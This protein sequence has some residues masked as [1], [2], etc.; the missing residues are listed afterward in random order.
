[1]KSKHVANSNRSALPQ[2]A[3]WTLPRRS[4]L[5]RAL[6]TG[7]LAWAGMGVL[8]P[9]WAQSNPRLLVLGDS[10]SA[11]YGIP[12][13]SGWVAQ[14]GVQLQA[15]AS[16]PW[17]LIN[18]SMS[19]ETTAGGHAR[20]PSLLAKHRPQW[21]I[22]ELGGNDALRGL[23]LA[24]TRLKLGEMIKA[25]TEAGARVLLIGIQ[26]PP[27]YGP[28]YNQGLQQIYTQLAAQNKGTLLLPFFL[29]GVA[30][31]PDARRYFLDDGIH[32]NQAAQPIL[33]RN[34]WQI[35][36]KALPKKKS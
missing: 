16:G 3:E 15:H 2:P 27:N 4:F 30:D 23:P 35:L 12:R 6:W 14:L 8:T 28:D 32:P 1:M 21:V 10:L 7:G 22:L 34:V 20:L 31:G 11:E 24:Q 36:S 29:A 18:A 33:M 25:C 5:R 19:G 17:E 26:V 13:G 9:A